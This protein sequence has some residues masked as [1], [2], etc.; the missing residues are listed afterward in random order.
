M[1]LLCKLRVLILFLVWFLAQDTTSQDFGSTL[2]EVIEDIAAKSDDELPEDW[3][4]HMYE[5]AEHPLNL[6]SATKEELERIR[7]LTLYEIENLHHYIYEYGELYSI[8]ELLAVKGFD[9]QTVRWL[10]HI[11]K[12]GKVENLTYGRYNKKDTVFIKHESLFRISGTAE[13]LKGTVDGSF[14]GSPVQLLLKHKTEAGKYK[15]GLV[16]EKD[17]GEMFWDTRLQRPEYLAY[18][19]EHKDTGKLKHMIIG[20]YRVNFGQGLNL[21]QNFGFGKSSMIMNGVKSGPV[22]TRHSSASEYNYFQGAAATLNVLNSEFS[23]FGSYRK[24]DATIRKTDEQLLVTSVGETGYHRTESEHNRKANL[25]QS[26]FGMRLSKGFSKIKIGAS[27]HTI[28][29][30]YPV[31]VVS[32]NYNSRYYK[33]LS[34]DFLY[35]GYSIIGW[36]ELGADLNG[37]LAGLL[38]LNIYPS[39]IFSLSL[40]ARSF[41]SG[42]QVVYS[43]PFSETGKSDNEKGI[44]LGVEVLPFA[45]V[46]VQSYLDVF[47]FYAPRFNV[48][49]PSSGFEN[50]TAVSWILTR[51]TNLNV[52]FKYEQKE[53]NYSNGIFNAVE[54]FDKMSVRLSLKS[55]VL[56]GLSL[57]SR[58]DYVTN[59]YSGSPE[60]GWMFLQDVKVKMPHPGLG[61]T[62]RIAF[63]STDSYNTGVYVYEPDVLYAF[64]VPVYYGQGLRFLMNVNYKISKHTIL[65]VKCGRFVYRDRESVSSGVTEIQD[66]IKTDLRFQIRFKF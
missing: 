30:D 44:Y 4:E 31:S 18:Y 27:F 50:L 6:N 42:Y 57:Q 47:R 26:A 46:K 28:V 1:E 43:S 60:N 41:P 21:W 33:G 22:F 20:N 52:R 54:P 10:M 8:Y 35:S 5:L 55:D 51:T 40:V 62:G 29:Y 56:E 15:A 19:L 45:G 13:P 37:K 36:G 59:T 49:A 2:E 12:V 66:N 63:F 16:Y 65:Y 53:K 34:A 23:V 25:Q 39:S 58:I 11:V 61:I 24:P 64:S 14:V 7:F 17:A 9:E 38:G 32:E 48:D 3:I